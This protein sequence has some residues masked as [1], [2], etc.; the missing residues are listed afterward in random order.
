MVADHGCCSDEG[1]AL[2]RDRGPMQGAGHSV[3]P[4]RVRGI[5]CN[6]AVA[7][8]SLEIEFMSAKRARALTC[9][10]LTLHHGID[11]PR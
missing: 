5:I 8:S 9:L 1:S 3:K 4:H 7:P 6:R 2:G 10:R 11:G